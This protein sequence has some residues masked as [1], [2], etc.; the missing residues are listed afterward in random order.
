MA[1]GKK[2][3][4]GSDF[5]EML[6]EMITLLGVIPMWEYIP[7]LSWMRRFDG[8][9][10]RIEK[11]AKAFDEFLEAVIEE[12]RVRER[13]EGDGGELDFVDI[14][15]DFQKEN[16]SHSPVEDDTIKAIVP[17]TILFL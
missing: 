17:V 3:G 16:A 10:G 12:H 5:K 2:Y 13:R 4:L 14:L 8:V 15:L 1:L 11:V 7:W 6:T 9:D